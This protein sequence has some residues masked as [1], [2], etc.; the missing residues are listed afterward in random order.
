M[1]YMSFKE[2]I[3]LYGLKDQAT[4]NIK[5]K[6]VLDKLTIPS[7]IYMRYD[8]FTTPLGIVNLHPTEGTHWFMFSDKFYFGSNGCLPFFKHN[9]TNKKWSLFRISNSERR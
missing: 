9:E 8:K 7:G 3:D 6:E 4:S 5:T 2:F 1:K